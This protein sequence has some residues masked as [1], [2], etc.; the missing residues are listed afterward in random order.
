MEQTTHIFGYKDKKI[1][2][3]IAMICYAVHQLHLPLELEMIET[4]KI[5]INKNDDVFFQKANGGWIVV[6]Y[7]GKFACAKGPDITQINHFGIT[8]EDALEILKIMRRELHK[9]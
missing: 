9:L 6:T 5:A 4:K 3:R 1:R 8:R 7:E 2:Q